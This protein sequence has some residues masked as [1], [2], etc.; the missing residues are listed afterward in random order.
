MT[1]KTLFYEVKNLFPALF[2]QISLNFMTM[3]IL[4]QLYFHYKE[5][6]T[7]KLLRQIIIGIGFGII[8][9]ICLRFPLTLPDSS[10]PIFIGSNIFILAA[11]YGGPVGMFIALMIGQIIMKPGRPSQD[12][13]ANDPNMIMPSG[14]PVE[15]SSFQSIGGMLADPDLFIILFGIV[16]VLA[17]RF[18]PL[19]NWQIWLCLNI[20]FQI[21]L[22]LMLGDTLTTS[23]IRC[24]IEIISGA[25]I[26]YYVDYM[27]R[28]YQSKKQL[29]QLATK[30]S[31]TGAYN[32]GYYA[33]ASE[34][35]F[36]EAK[37]GKSNFA[38]LIMDVDH[39][40]HINDT[41]GH[42]VGDQVLKEMAGLLK[43]AF[44]GR[45]DIVCRN[46]GEEF[47]VLIPHRDATEVTR[48]AEQFQ[49]NVRSHVFAADRE[50]LSLRLTVS[51]GICFYS[52]DCTTHQDIYERADRALYQAKHNG[53]NQICYADSHLA[54]SS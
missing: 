5:R 10:M 3:F 14:G 39:F 1:Y 36:A 35:L 12:Q 23:L 32:A 45:H 44:S 30:D 31:L 11:V 33:M 27:H 49:E 18:L 9:Y 2:Q 48:A 43:N 7:S 41:Y 20:L 52:K 26:Y 53:R 47:S 42:P 28:A 24:S 51:V 6:I 40:K 54:I 22:Y 38:L 19:K 37:R 21:K 13:A 4:F 17:F 25:L 29:E 46:G 50:D 16:A 8:Q 34:R 15:I